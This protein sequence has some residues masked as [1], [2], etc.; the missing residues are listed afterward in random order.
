MNS[1]DVPD[2]FQL[3][4]DTGETMMSSGG[5]PC[6]G[7]NIRCALEITRNW[8]RLVMHLR[9]K[10]NDDK[11]SIAVLFRIS[12]WLYKQYQELSGCMEQISTW[13]SRQIWKE[14]LTLYQKSLGA[15]F[16]V[17]LQFLDDTFINSMF[18]IFKAALHIEIFTWTWDHYRPFIF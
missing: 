7:P 12:P 4:S 14:N 2:I 17:P 9:E 6:W 1:Q 18:Q 3:D 16:Q 11:C 15:L 8:C 10:N 5:I 13:H